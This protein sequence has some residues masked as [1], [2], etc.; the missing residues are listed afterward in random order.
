MISKPK[1]SRLSCAESIVRQ[2]WSHPANRHQRGRAL[3]RAVGWQLHKR[4]IRK[5]REITVFSGMRIRC[6]PAST[7]ASNLF[8]FGQYYEYD[9]MR[10][11]ARYL[12][13]GDGFIDGGANIGTYSLLA[14]GIVG[15]GGRV[16]AFEPGAEAAGWFRENLA[17]NGLDWVELHEAALM[18]RA[19]TAVYL[20]DW[21]VSNRILRGKAT[22]ANQIEVPCVSL[23]GTLPPGTQYAMAKLDLEGAEVMALRG[24]EKHLTDA[25]PPVWQVEVIDH[26]LHDMGSSQ[27]ELFSIFSDHGYDIARYDS[28]S[29]S[30]DF[31]FGGVTREGENV[32]AIS[33]SRRNEI[34]GRLD[35][36]AIPGPFTDRAGGSA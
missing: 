33:R 30:L 1:Y 24:A 18:E 34:S 32:M 19:G 31:D 36:S 23:D 26:L 9:E 21:D 22:E 11:L 3:A 7:S 25:N 14:A 15:P 17:L 5:P 29:N 35:P 28:D 6:H 8:Y 27:R 2:V 4:V 16:D 12:R 13:P 10:F 20:T